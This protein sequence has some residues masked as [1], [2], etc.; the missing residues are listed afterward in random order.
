VDEV[1]IQRD[2]LM[3]FLRK[4]PQK[5]LFRKKCPKTLL[6]KSVAKSYAAVF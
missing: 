5:A 4:R 6:K 1:W 2:F 3:A